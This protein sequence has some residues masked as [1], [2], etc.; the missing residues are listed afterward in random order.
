[1][2]ACPA[3]DLSSYRGIRFGIDLPSA[4]KLLGLDPREARVMQRR[5][6]TRE[7]ID[8][9]PGW[10]VG[11]SGLADSDGIPQSVREV[12]LSFYEGSLYRMVATYDR[13]RI[14]GLSTDDLIEMISKDSGPATR[15][16]VDIPYHTMY[17]TSAAVLGRWQDATYQWNL[18]RTGD[19]AGYALVLRASEADE[20]AEAAGKEAVR[21][22]RI[23][24][25]EREAAAKRERA[26]AE[27]MRQEKA[28][29][30]NKIGFQP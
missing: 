11:P 18:V 30:A 3:A 4:A 23:E 26:E 8:W 1:M 12:T 19:G 21:L 17:G 16:A 24:A 6:G 5:P 9:H 25:P 7:E 22:E 10:T 2:A 13:T 15:P 14:E 27:L 28:R 29:A 20:R